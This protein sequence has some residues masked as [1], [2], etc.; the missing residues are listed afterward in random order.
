[1]QRRYPGMTTDQ[2]RLCATF[3]AGPICSFSSHPPDTLKTVLQGDIERSRY[4]S[5]TQAARSIVAERGATALWA[6]LPWRVLRQFVAVFL[7]DKI[8]S[9]YAPLIFPHAFVD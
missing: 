5:Y 1:M 9:D 2:A 8:R 7:F 4:S 3:V 6:G